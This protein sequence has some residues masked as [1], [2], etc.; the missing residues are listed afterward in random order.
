[1]LTC[2]EIIAPQYEEAG[3]FSDGLA[4]VRKDGKWG[5][6][7]TAGEV[8]IPFQYE[9]AFIFN[10]GKAIVCKKASYAPEYLE[11]EDPYYDVGFIDET[12]KYTPFLDLSGS[13]AQL[14]EGDYGTNDLFFHNGFAIFAPVS[15]ERGLDSVY[16][17]DGKSLGLKSGEY[18]WADSDT[19]SDCYATGPVNEG[20]IP[21]IADG[22][23]SAGWANLD[24]TPAS[25]FESARILFDDGSEVNISQTGPFNQGLAPVWQS[26]YS[27]DG[28]TTLIGFMNTDFEWVIKPQFTNFFYS[29]VNGAYQV[30]GATGLAMV[31]KDGKYGAIDKSGNT[32]IPFRYDELWPVR[33]GMIVF[34]LNG[35]YGYLDAATLSVAIPAQYELASGFSGGMAVVYDGAKAYIIDK[36]GAPIPGADSLASSTYFIQY[37]DG[38][39]VV[40]EPEEYVVIE[41]EGKYG[42][43]H[44]EFKPELPKT[45]EMSSWAYAEVT[46]AIEENLVPADLQNLYLNNI[47]RSEFSKLVVQAINQVLDQDIQD[48]VL[49]QTGRSLSSWQAEYPFTDSSDSEVIAAY[50][51]GIVTGRGNG[52]FD[53]YASITRQE[54]AAF[55]MRS[56]KVLGMDTTKITAAAFVD[57]SEVGVWFTDAV[58]FVYQIN[59]M[60]GTGNNTF[61][62]L[63]TYTREQSYITIYRL[64]QA[65]MNL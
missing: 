63:G 2:T 46:A 14:Y 42:Y 18:D 48:V 11:R 6:I 38:S 15:D 44:I 24:G 22:I 32:V 50:A 39:K 37:D 65:V 5:Y 31:Q 25:D 55:L 21:V 30:F 23:W 3:R 41:A 62:P 64:F 52:I 54:A 59:V 43:G 35:K 47:T 45:D 17:K 49:D 56:A 34:R 58:N 26:T 33:E 29:G 40:Y 36:E 19:F 53:P 28:G 12:G 9:M 51:L 8:V 20:L 10:E 7:N 1:M 61:S 16:R 57:G 13:A 60:S 27:A 4:A